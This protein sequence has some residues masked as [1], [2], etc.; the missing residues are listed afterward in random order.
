[1]YMYVPEANGG[2]ILLKQGSVGREERGEGEG[3]REGGGEKR[4][5]GEEGG[6]KAF[7]SEEFFLETP[8]IITTIAPL[9]EEADSHS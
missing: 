5:G 8:I 6:G 4:G 9:L 7:C 1:M 2:G 3:R